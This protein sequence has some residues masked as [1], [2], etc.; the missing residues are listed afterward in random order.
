MNK[1]L[2]TPGKP[3]SPLIRLNLDLP[4][5]RSFA[6]MA[7][8]APEQWSAA[9]DHADVRIGDNRFTGDLHSYRITVTLDEIELDVTLTGTVHSWRPET[10]F[11]LFGEDRAKE[12]AWLRDRRPVHRRAH[13]QTCRRHHPL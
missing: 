2:T 13:G 6:K 12:F 8:F 5:G 9:T 7:H 10:G 1:D 11:M 4:D 3:L